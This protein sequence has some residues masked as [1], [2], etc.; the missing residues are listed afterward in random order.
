M[1]EDRALEAAVL[2]D[3]AE[4]ILRIR[5]LE[6]RAASDLDLAMMIREQQP[7]AARDTCIEALG[8]YIGPHGCKPSKYRATHHDAVHCILVH[9][10]R[11]GPGSAQRLRGLVGRSRVSRHALPMRSRSRFHPALTAPPQS[12]S[13]QTTGR[14]RSPSFARCVAGGPVAPPHA[15]GH[16]ACC[17]QAAMTSP[18]TEPSASGSQG[19]TRQAALKAVDVI[20]GKYM[21]RERIGEGGMGSVFLADQLTLGRSVVIKVL[22]PELAA[23]PDLASK[24]QNEAMLAC[25]VRS[26]HCVEVFDCGVLPDGAPYIVMEYVPGRPLGR[27]I[28]DEPMP[29]PRALDVCDQIL[30]ALDAVHRSGIVHGDVKSDNF[31]I[32]HVRGSDHVTM[33]DF[34]LAHVIGESTDADLANELAISGTPEYMAPEVAAGGAPLPASDLYGAGVILYELLTGTTPF[35]GG[36]AIEV[37]ARQARDRAIPPSECRPDRGIP[38]EIDRVVLQALDKRPDARFADAAAFAG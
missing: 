34:G 37:M 19:C 21:V 3:Q 18:V 29:L 1:V 13:G 6:Q 12:A 2:S 35:C 9:R 30:S 25:H 8:R 27:I 4:R 33:I 24:M 14:P 36:T 31:L 32:E 15:S 5:A 28:A 16:G 23:V 22:Q 26:P 17:T 20:D 11:I 38:P 10:L 7:R